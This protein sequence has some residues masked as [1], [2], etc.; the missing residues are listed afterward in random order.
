MRDSMARVLAG[1][2]IRDHI[3]GNLEYAS[4]MFPESISLTNDG[5]IYMVDNSHLRRISDGKISTIERDRPYL[6]AAMVRIFEDDVYLLI[7]PFDDI[8]GNFVYGIQ[9]LGD[10]LNMYIAD[11]RF[12]SI[13]DF[14]ISDDGI[15]YFIE[16]NKATD[17]T[18][19]KSMELGDWHNHTVLAE[20]LPEDSGSL[21]MADDG[22]IFFT[23]PQ[24][25]MI[26]MYQNGRVS[27]IAGSSENKA[28]IDGNAPQFYMP[29]RLSY[30]DGSLY[31]WDFNTLRRIE[32]NGGVAY[33]TSSVLGVASPTY[34]EELPDHPIPPHEVVLPFSRYA[35][36]ITTQDEIILTDPLRGAVWRIER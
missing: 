27:T 9:K 12:T 2:D 7:D 22:T 24:T 15:M 32:M 31:V 26:K 17:Q 25:G 36:F 10:P 33:R 14:V 13:L 28:F 19:L 29:L 8:N 3:D 21:T 30:A 18:L 34:D 4:L 5:T 1:N 6:A 16:N 35:D 11:A 20:D 23:S